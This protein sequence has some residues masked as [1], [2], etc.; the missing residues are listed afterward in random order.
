MIRRAVPILVRPHKG[1]HIIKPVFI[2]KI[3]P[4]LNTLTLAALKC[5]ATALRPVAQPTFK[6]DISFTFNLLQTK[7]IP[8]SFN[9]DRA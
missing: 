9:G 6:Q 4:S 7:P 8:H 1:V 2:N 5:W 3:S